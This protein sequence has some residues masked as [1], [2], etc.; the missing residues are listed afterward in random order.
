MCK[1]R[2]PADGS[3]SSPADNN[4]EHRYGQ[5]FSFYFAMPSTPL[6]VYRRI[7]VLIS[8]NPSGFPFGEIQRGVLYFLFR[9][10]ESA[11]EITLKIVLVNTHRVIGT[12]PSMH[13]DTIVKIPHTSI[14]I[15]ETIRV[16]ILNAVDT[17]SF[18]P[19]FKI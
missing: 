17:L 18:L 12:K 3:K 13:Q 19:M 7:L 16:S 15:D 6:M 10:K 9:M 1:P 14:P 5:C 4:H 11:K 8:S 2:W